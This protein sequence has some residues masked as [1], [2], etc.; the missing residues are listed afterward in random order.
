MCAADGDLLH[1]LLSSCVF[2]QVCVHVC[3]RQRDRDGD[4]G[5]ADREAEMGTEAT[6]ENGKAG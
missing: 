2:L 6:A 4:R 1:F 5:R 3:V